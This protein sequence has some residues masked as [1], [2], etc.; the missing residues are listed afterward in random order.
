MYWGGVTAEVIDMAEY[1]Q[2]YSE[3]LHKLAAARGVELRLAVDGCVTTR[4]RISLYGRMSP[5]WRGQIGGAQ[6]LGSHNYYRLAG[7]KFEGIGQ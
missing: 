7:M 5:E 2:P 6:P 3:K 4:T 1:G